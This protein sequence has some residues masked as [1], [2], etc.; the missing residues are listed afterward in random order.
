M[1]AK[2]LTQAQQA[3]AQGVSLPTVKR[4]RNRPEYIDAAARILGKIQRKTER[5]VDEAPD[6]SDLPLG[7]VLR[8]ADRMIATLRIPNDDDETALEA[9]RHRTLRDAGYRCPCG[10]ED[11]PCRLDAP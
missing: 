4:D 11:E 1:A 8:I 5:F 2:G 10:P 3:Q 6:G 7:D 9:A